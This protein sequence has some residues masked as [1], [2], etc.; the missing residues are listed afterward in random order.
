MKITQIL[1][2]QHI[3]RSIAKLWFV[4]RERVIQNTQAEQYLSR[5]GIEV[6]DPKDVLQPK[7]TFPRYLYQIHIFHKLYMHVYIICTY[8]NYVS[9]QNQDRTC[10]I[11]KTII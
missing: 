8:I 2:K 4:K 5:F 9:R 3:G 7:Q 1:Y 11:S 6:K 10:N